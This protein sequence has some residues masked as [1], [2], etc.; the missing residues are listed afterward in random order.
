MAT[1]TQ[2]DRELDWST[3]R[4]LERKD[5][6]IAGLR[7]VI[8]KRD[9]EIEQLR[10]WQRARLETSD[11]DRTE[12]ELLRK[13]GRDARD[14]AAENFTRAKNAEAE[15]ERLRAALHEA[16]QALNL[17][18]LANDFGG[19]AL[20]RPLGQHAREGH[21]DLCGKGGYCPKCGSPP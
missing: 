4:E 9:Q 2:A 3:G 14:L 21:S 12:I 17:A 7:E 18:L 10:A 16:R 6:E 13:D 15:V 8:V 20:T 1:R 11:L 19:D 5:A